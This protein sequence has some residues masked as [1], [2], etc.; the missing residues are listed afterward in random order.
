MEAYLKRQTR[1]TAE[2]MSDLLYS[3]EDAYDGCH[4][5]NA[6]TGFLLEYMGRPVSQRESDKLQGMLMDEAES[7]YEGAVQELYGQAWERAFELYG[8]A[9]KNPRKR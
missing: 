5:E 2:K 7:G 6:A 8:H 4:I 9:K 3:E 1:Q